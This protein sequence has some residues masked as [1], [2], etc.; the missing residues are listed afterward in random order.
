MIKIFSSKLVLAM[1]ALMV[2]TVA[3]AAVKLTI[4]QATN[5]LPKST[6][7]IPVY[8][9]NDADVST[10]GFDVRFPKGITPTSMVKNNERAKGVQGWAC[11]I[12]PT[13]ENPGAYRAGLYSFEKKV[14]PGEGVI[15]TITAVCADVI[16]TGEITLENVE[17]TLTSG[18]VAEVE[19]ENG[20]VVTNN[21]YPGTMVFSAQDVITYPGEEF[22]V[23]VALENDIELRSFQA[24]LQL[25][26]GFEVAFDEEEDAYKI[27]GSDRAPE[28]TTFPYNDAKGII[29]MLNM[30]GEPLEGNE[31]TLFTFTVKAP[32]EMP[33]NSVIAIK[34]F[35]GQVKGY[36]TSFDFNS[37]ITI[38]VINQET[39]KP[40]VLPGD[41]NNDGTVDAI[42]LALFI[43]ALANKQLPAAATE[44]FERYDANGDKALNIA[45][46]Q[47]IFNIII[48]K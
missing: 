20:Q 4:G 18:D 47:A 16:E 37:D 29:A 32:A 2:G 38:N 12:Q 24:N 48:S 17:V 15:A 46:A 9:E 14:A 33:D 11:N 27:A 8:L 40:E 6:I 3:N 7:E 43:Q 45:D 10:I 22:T 34:G 26:E 19:T 23:A 41:I 36:T 31:G 35:K 21:V 1:L 42:D 25:P 13:V 28:G 44:D 30:S 5:A 39:L